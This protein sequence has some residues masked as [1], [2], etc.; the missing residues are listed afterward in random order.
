MVPIRPDLAQSGALLT[1]DNRPNPSHSAQLMARRR[2][3]RTSLEE[4][5]SLEPRYYEPALARIGAEGSDHEGCE[6]NGA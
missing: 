5:Q 6:T 4:R 1:G 3:A 2:L